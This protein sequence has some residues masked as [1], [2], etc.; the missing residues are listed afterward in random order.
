MP[1]DP[2]PGGRYV[3]E[4][5]P[6]EG[7]DRSK[8]ISIGDPVRV[9]AGRFGNSLRVKGYVLPDRESERKVYVRGTGLVSEA[10]PGGR[11]QLTRVG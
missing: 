3:T 1:A 2:R 5:I 4:D 9:P 7:K 6:G 8:V 10:D 11:L